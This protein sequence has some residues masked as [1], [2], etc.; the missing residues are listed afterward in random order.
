M[1]C[2]S[3]YL[4]CSADENAVRDGCETYVVDNLN[5]CGACGRVCPNDWA[6]ATPSCAANDCG[7]LCTAP[8]DNCDGL[9]A[10]GCE[11]NLDTDGNNCGTCSR[12]CDSTVCRARICLTTTRYG[13]TGPGATTTSFSPNYLAGIQVY[14][15][16]ASV[17]TGFGVVIHSSGTARSM[18]IGLY[19]DV[20]G[21]PSNLVATASG[22]FQA[23]PGGTEVPVA[24]QVD[25]PAGNYWLLGVW[26]GSATFAA[27]S[28][29]PVP[30]RFSAHSF[31]PVPSA[32]PVAMEPV[33]YAP[34]NIYAIVAQ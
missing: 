22:P 14:I 33:S 11:T 6:H 34:P 25:I 13:N 17:I 18:Y 32:A 24:T 7:H 26:N 29:T 23:T 3:G 9:P 4:D 20:A 28:T 31:G 30:W 15:A 27:N 2:A 21:S 1:T 5:N 12:T 8:W 10:T 16:Q 19:R